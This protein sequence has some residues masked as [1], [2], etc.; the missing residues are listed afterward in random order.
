M[1]RFV[2][3]ENEQHNRQCL[4]RAAAEKGFQNRTGRISL[5]VAVTAA[6][7]MFAFPAGGQPPGEVA[8]DFRPGESYIETRA[9]AGE[10]GIEGNN[11]RTV[12]AWVYKRGLQHVPVFSMGAHQDFSETLCLRSRGSLGKWRLWGPEGVKMAALG[13]TYPSH[14]RWVHFA[15][16]HTGSVS[17]VYA[18][19]QEVART[20][21][22]L[23]THADEELFRIGR[24][25]GP[26]GLDF[27]GKVAEVRVWNRALSGEEIRKNMNASL[28]GDE[29]GLVGYW[30]LNE[31]EGNVAHDLAQNNHGRLTGAVEWC[32]I[33]PFVSDLPDA[34]RVQA[35]PGDGI[36]VE[37]GNTITLGPVELRNPRG[38]V[39]YQ[40]YRENESIEG[41]T[42]NVLK[43]ENLNTGHLGTY[44]HVELNDERDLTPVESNRVYIAPLRLSVHAPFTDFLK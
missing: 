9:T 4:K 29:D 3:R 42:S 23:S 13:F 1:L 34:V 39:S 22:E 28:K 38:D 7:L 24:W 10:M 2:K 32:L 31:G 27:D 33:Q 37:P 40:W 30:P 14:Q 26:P 5:I 21:G 6:T 35:A 17:I 43:I 18:D 44:Y 36:E 25:R 8:L 12:E 11:A 16:V 15:I 41:A 20:W 19:G